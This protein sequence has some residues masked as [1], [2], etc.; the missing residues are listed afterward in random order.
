MW[1]KRSFSTLASLLGVLLVFVRFAAIAPTPTQATPIHPE[2]AKGA[3]KQAMLDASIAQV[4]NAAGTTSRAYTQYTPISDDNDI[5]TAQV[6]Q[7][8][9]ETET[10]T[11]VYK[12]QPVGVFVAASANL[13]EFNATQAQS[14]LFIG[15]SSTLARNNQVNDLL[16]LESVDFSRKCKYKGRTDYKDKF[17]EGRYDY[18]TTCLKGT[19]NALVLVATPKDRSML[20][21]VRMVVVDN[22]DLQAATKLYQTFQVKNVSLLEGKPA[23]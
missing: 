21:L 17:Y 11:W 6:P 9:N 1:Y 14:G 13:A 3:I 7:A 20:I 15:A 2:Q 4:P 23:H 19:H 16:A 8:W 12:G 22:A 5:I 10:G 18:Y